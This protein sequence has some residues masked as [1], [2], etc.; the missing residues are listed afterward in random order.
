MG[1]DI[2]W[3][4]WTAAGVTWI[5][6]TGSRKIMSESPSSWR[7]RYIRWATT[8]T[9]I[10][11]CYFPT[12]FDR[13]KINRRCGQSKSSLTLYMLRNSQSR[14]LG[15]RWVT[16]T[17]V[18]YIEPSSEKAQTLDNN[19]RWRYRMAFDHLIH[20]IKVKFHHCGH[21]KL[22]HTLDIFCSSRSHRRRIRCVTKNN[23]KM[24]FKP[25]RRYIR[26]ATT[27][28]I[29]GAWYLPTWFNRIE[30]NRRCS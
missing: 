4:Y 14:K 9:I 30:I 20:R 3:T 16:R 21:N 1:W 25:T 17:T 13:I 12:W 6:A 10:G 5:G 18:K 23:V 24:L 19:N 27:A 28:T 22:V 11:A 7:K 26:W 2:R 8:A 15:F 29:A